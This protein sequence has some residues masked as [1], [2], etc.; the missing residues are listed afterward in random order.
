[1]IY[2]IW[3]KLQRNVVNN[4]GKITELFYCVCSLQNLW[5]LSL[6]GKKLVNNTSSWMVLTFADSGSHVHTTWGLIDW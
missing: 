5:I 6:S 3:D 2:M 4:V 1:M